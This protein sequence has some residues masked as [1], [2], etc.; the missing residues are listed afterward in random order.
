M[1][2]IVE[3]LVLLIVPVAILAGMV[4]GMYR[5]RRWLVPRLPYV[6]TFFGLVAVKTQDYADLAAM[7]VKE[8]HAYTAGVKAASLSVQAR[9]LA[10][11]SRW[12]DRL[13]RP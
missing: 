5:L 12:L 10:V 3:A 8:A 6:H 2:L 13:A 1:L 7:P 9:I 11:V 4:Y